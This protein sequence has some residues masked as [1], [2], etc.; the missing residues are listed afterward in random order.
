[1]YRFYGHETADVKPLEK[2]AMIRDPRHMYDILA[3]LWCAETCAARMRDKW[4]KENRTLGQC[5]ITAFLVQDVFGGEVY[6]IRRPDGNYHCY[7]VVS[8]RLFDLTSEQF[9]GEVLDYSDNPLQERSVHF[10]DGDKKA[11]YELLSRR[12][13]E[14]I[15]A[16]S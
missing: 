13:H 7:N 8:G 6:G 15:S 10:A 1:M 12:F 11:R 3:E 4:T 14:S 16:L 2:Y 5:S 9:G